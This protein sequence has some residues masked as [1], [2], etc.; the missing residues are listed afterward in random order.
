MGLFWLFEVSF[1]SLSNLPPDFPLFQLLHVVSQQRKLL[2]QT[3]RVLEM[4]VVVSKLLPQNTRHHSPGVLNNLILT[5]RP[6][7]KLLS[8]GVVVDLVLQLLSLLLEVG[9]LFE[10]LDLKL[11]DLA[12]PLHDLPLQELYSELLLLGFCLFFC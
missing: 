1:E 8:H 2:G 5:L 6:L 9:A 3:G 12:V 4:V 10:G 7:S 11:G